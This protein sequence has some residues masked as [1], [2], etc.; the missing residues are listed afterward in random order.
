MLTSPMNNS[1]PRLVGSFVEF[2]KICRDAEAYKRND[3][4]NKRKLYSALE[5]IKN[6]D[7]FV[8]DAF[9]AA[10]NSF[11]EAGKPLSISNEGGNFLGNL[12]NKKGHED[13][14]AALHYHI[15]REFPGQGVKLN[16]DVFESEEIEGIFTRDATLDSANTGVDQPLGSP[17]VVTAAI[18]GTDGPP[19]SEINSDDRGTADMRITITGQNGET[20]S[21]YV[22]VLNSI[23]PKI[24]KL[25][26][27][28]IKV[29][30]NVGAVARN[31]DG[32][33]PIKSMTIILF[34]KH[35]LYRSILDELQNLAKEVKADDGTSRI[36]VR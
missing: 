32:F 26:Y 14:C 21:T 33:P 13:K 36:I 1:L 25:E 22:R 12:K 11:T 27:D 6:K 17:S 34:Q 31:S 24:F 5:G 3:N 20:I 7:G 18:S 9:T 2:R 15:L 8:D 10:V 30:L 23:K 19:V 35:Y 28:G 29:E 16:C 4:D